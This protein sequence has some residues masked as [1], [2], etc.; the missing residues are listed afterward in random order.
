MG[1]ILIGKNISF[2][3]KGPDVFSLRR[4]GFIARGKAWECE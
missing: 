4:R 1:E 3:R 2:L